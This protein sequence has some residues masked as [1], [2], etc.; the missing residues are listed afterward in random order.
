[1]TVATLG[2]LLTA[3]DVQVNKLAAPLSVRNIMKTSV[4][5]CVRACVRERVI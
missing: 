1:M 5:A 4:R 3:G 2:E